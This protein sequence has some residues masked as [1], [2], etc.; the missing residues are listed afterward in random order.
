MVAVFTASAVVAETWGHVVD[1]LNKFRGAPSTESVVS[2]EHPHVPSV[3]RKQYRVV[4]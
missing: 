4:R 2:S 1:V 3:D